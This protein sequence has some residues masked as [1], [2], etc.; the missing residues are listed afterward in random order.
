MPHR[1]PRYNEARRRFD[2]LDLEARTR[3]LVEATA[4][5]LAQGVLHV[6]RALA[7]R[8][9]DLLRGGGRGPE[10]SRPG[11]GAAEP[12]TAQRQ[13]PRGGTSPARDA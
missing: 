9:E 3:F 13:A 7:D 5:T 8:L 12:E 10:M 1:D 2:A 11:P 6:G 4:S